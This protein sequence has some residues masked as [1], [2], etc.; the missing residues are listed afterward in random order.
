MRCKPQSVCALIRSVPGPE[1]I[2]PREEGAFLG[3][4][5]SVWVHSLALS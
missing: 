4:T 5:V 3:N 1:Q 2:K